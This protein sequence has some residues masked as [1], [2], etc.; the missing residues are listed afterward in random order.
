M[1]VHR[2]TL[3]VCVYPA[4]DNDEGNNV[5]GSEGIDQDEDDG[6]HEGDEKA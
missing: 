3:S 2:R 5:S 1:I 6:G 4:P